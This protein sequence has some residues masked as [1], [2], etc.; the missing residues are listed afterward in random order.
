MINVIKY[1]HPS[2]NALAIKL[3]QRVEVEMA[4]MCMPQPRRLEGVHRHAHWAAHM[5]CEVVQLAAIP[6]DL[7]E[8]VP[9]KVVDARI[10]LLMAMRQPDSSNW[11]TLMMLGVKRGM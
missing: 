6:H 10:P 3:P 8:K 1:G 7:G 2:N 4:E 11:L 9:G 5:Q